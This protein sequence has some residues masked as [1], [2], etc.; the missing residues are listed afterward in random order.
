MYLGYSVTL[1][2]T[3]LLVMA[4][5]LM[6]CSKIW[7]LNKSMDFNCLVSLNR[8]CTFWE[9]LFLIVAMLYFYQIEANCL[10]MCLC[11][12]LVIYGAL[13]L[14]VCLFIHKQNCVYKSYSFEYTSL[15]S[16]MNISVFLHFTFLSY[17]RSL[18]NISL[19]LFAYT[20]KLGC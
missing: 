1:T 15:K 20:V 16:L 8:L 3:W 2:V 7:L 10:V 12:T 14:T 11:I 6:T 4:L 13:C 5:T 17:S 18:F 9:C 19:A